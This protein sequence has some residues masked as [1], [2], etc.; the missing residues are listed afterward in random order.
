MSARWPTPRPSNSRAESARK[1]MLFA[2]MMRIL[3][4]L[5]G[6]RDA[7]PFLC[8][9]LPPPN[10]R[11]LAKYVGRSPPEGAKLCCVCLARLEYRIS[12]PNPPE[13]TAEQST[14]RTA[15]SDAPESQPTRALSFATQ[16]KRKQTSFL[17][18]F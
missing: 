4:G 16:S 2:H 9:S 14:H 8:S 15:H 18:D 1:S 11:K 5:G 7:R 10:L 12:A 6:A 13:M 3:K 17:A